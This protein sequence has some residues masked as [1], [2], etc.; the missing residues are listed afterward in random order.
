M[1]DRLHKKVIKEG[2]F[3][4]KKGYQNSFLFLLLTA[5][6]VVAVVEGRGELFVVG[7]GHE[8]LSRHSHCSS[9]FDLR[10]MS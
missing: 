4:Y 1:L 9:R 3:Y 5:V 2:P 7:I 8:G 10:L 6:L